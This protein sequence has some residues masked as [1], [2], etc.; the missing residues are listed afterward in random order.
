MIHNLAQ[1]FLDLLKGEKCSRTYETF[2]K[3]SLKHGPRHGL[4][5]RLEFHVAFVFIVKS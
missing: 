5:T 3:I 1:S 4:Q 2:L